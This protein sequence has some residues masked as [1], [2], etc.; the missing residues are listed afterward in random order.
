MNR[1]ST[2]IYE[3]IRLSVGIEAVE[4]LIADLDQALGSW[5]FLAV[6]PSALCQ[7]RPCFIKKTPA[8]SR[9][10]NWFC[11]SLMPF[12]IRAGR[13]IP[14][15]PLLLRINDA[16]LNVSHV[17]ERQRCRNDESVFGH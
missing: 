4:D 13:A 15:C 16:A 14:G 6:E 17:G 2:P 11:A 7:Y 12:A 3:L 10:L 9:G 5:N 8:M 1:G